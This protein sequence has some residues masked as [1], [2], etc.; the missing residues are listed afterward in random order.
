MS[1]DFGTYVPKHLAGQQTTEQL[2]II[3]VNIRAY[4]SAEYGSTYSVTCDNTSPSEIGATIGSIIYAGRD[5][6][7]YPESS[8]LPT[9]TGKYKAKVNIALPG[10]QN[11]KEISADFE[12]KPRPAQLNWSSSELTYNGQL[13]TVTA[14]VRN[15]LSD[16]TFKLTYVADEIYTNT[17]KNARKYTAKVTALGN[18]NYSLSEE[19]GRAHV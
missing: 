18:T 14:R 8:V 4:S 3:N 10:E 6:T 7:T 17:G 19:I 11:S 9:S 1:R 13:Q 16:D 5:G 2:Q 15:A 12:I